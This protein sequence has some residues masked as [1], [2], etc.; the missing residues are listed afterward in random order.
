MLELG[1]QNKST[2]TAASVTSTAAAPAP[3]SSADATLQAAAAASSLPSGT[4][5]IPEPSPVRI[6][7]VRAPVDSD[8]QRSEET[9]S[10]IDLQ[11]PSPAPGRK[12]AALD[13]SVDDSDQTPMSGGSS[14]FEDSRDDDGTEGT[15]LLLHRDRAVLYTCQ[16][17]RLLC[18][19]VKSPFS[20]SCSCSR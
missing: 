8:R 19:L 20:L 16:P 2:P 1:V 5:S 4:A 9:L 18:V 6:I 10:V 17:C 13:A 15:L 12:H 3:L 11:S 14:Q 7:A